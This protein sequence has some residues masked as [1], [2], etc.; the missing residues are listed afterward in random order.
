MGEPFRG[1]EGNFH[2]WVSRVVKGETSSENVR[3]S[4]MSSSLQPHGL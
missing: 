3:H 2:A 1:G 4:V